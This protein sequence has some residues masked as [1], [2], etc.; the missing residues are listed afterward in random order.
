MSQ[1]AG[2]RYKKKGSIK[3]RKT[4]GKKIKTPKMNSEEYPTSEQ[5]M[6]DLDGTTGMRNTDS[7]R[8]NV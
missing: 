2:V 7:W 6:D 3:V 4:T 8:H 1:R 5:M